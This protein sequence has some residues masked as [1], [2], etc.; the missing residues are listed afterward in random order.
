M[1]LEKTLLLEKASLL[2]KSEAQMPTRFQVNGKIQR[3]NEFK[4]Y[5]IPALTEHI[6]SSYI[7][8]QS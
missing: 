7:I 5:T 6:N 8:I 4:K 2:G 3:L 1:W